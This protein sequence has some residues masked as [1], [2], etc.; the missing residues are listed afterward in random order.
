MDHF[1]TV[2]PKCKEDIICYAKNF[3]EFCIYELLTG[4]NPKYEQLRV[5]ILGKDLLPTQ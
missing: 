5:T 1:L 2:R 3:E 4:L